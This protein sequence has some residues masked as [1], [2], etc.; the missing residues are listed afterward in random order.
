[1]YHGNDVGMHRAKETSEPEPIAANEY[2]HWESIA[3][4][5]P[6]PPIHDPVL[7]RTGPT[8]KYYQ[9]RAMLP[10]KCRFVHRMRLL[11]HLHRMGLHPMLVV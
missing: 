2:Q 9:L 10:L 1:M 6:P 5:P 4:V 7:L 8:H 3:T 11:G